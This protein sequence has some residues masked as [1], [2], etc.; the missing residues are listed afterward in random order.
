MSADLPKNGET[1]KLP[2]ARRQPSPLELTAAPAPGDFNPAGCR[3]ALDAAL[4]PFLAAWIR[5]LV[6]QGVCVIDPQTHTVRLKE[7]SA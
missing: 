6:E 4:S 2:R 1:H 7:K 5:E 3:L